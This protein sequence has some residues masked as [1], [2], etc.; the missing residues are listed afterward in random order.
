MNAWRPSRHPFDRG[1]QGRPPG[2]RTFRVRVR[3]AGPLFAGLA[4]RCLAGRPWAMLHLLSA[5]EGHP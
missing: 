5:W 2:W 3:L 1:T 4:A